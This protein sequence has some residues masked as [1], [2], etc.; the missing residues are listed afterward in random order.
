MALRTTM[1]KGGLAG[2][3]AKAKVSGE[4]PEGAPP[5]AARPNLPPLTHPKS[6]A[7]DRAVTEGATTGRKGP[8]HVLMETSR[9]AWVLYFLQSPHGIRCVLEQSFQGLFRALW[10]TEQQP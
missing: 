2:L 1:H 4:A 3:F 8:N 9:K 7:W 6:P 5:E 10:Q